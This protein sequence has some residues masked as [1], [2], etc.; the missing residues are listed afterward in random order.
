MYI[1]EYMTTSSVHSIG[2][3]ACVVHTA[4]TTVITITSTHVIEML[5]MCM[6]AHGMHSIGGGAQVAH[7][8]TVRKSMEHL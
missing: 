4:L 5:H 6:N 8:F 3:S 1:R 2:G 7:T